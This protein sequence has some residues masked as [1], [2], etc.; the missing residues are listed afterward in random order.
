[1]SKK[2]ILLL[3]KVYKNFIS[4]FL[5]NHCR[6]YPSCSLYA[7]IAIERY[8]VLWGG[9]LTLKRLLKCHPWYKGEGYDPVPEEIGFW[10]CGGRQ[11]SFVSNKK[12]KFYRDIL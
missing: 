4:P 2:I 10:G 9:W 5:G 7:E 11:K 8:G 12:M 1:M 6:F 3:I